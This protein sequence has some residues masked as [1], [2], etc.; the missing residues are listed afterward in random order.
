MVTAAQSLREDHVRLLFGLL[1]N[2]DDCARNIERIA[3]QERLAAR[4]FDG[5]AL[6]SL[7]ELRAQSHA[8]LADMEAQCRNLLALVGAPA[9]GEE[10]LPLST[11][12]D[13]YIAPRFADEAREL[14]SLRRALHARMLRAQADSEDSHIRLKAAFEVSRGVLQHIGAV[15]SPATYGPGG[16]P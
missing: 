9:F 6:A 15:E 4:R 14:Q 11:F 2:M 8:A 12:I 10:A 13:L 5:E 1:R 7:A 3:E 16:A